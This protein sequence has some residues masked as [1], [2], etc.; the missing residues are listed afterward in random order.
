[1]LRKLRRNMTIVMFCTND[2]KEKHQFSGR[3]ALLLSNF[4]F[5]LKSS[6]MQIILVAVCRFPSTA[7]VSLMTLEGVYIALNITQYAKN[8]HLKSFFLLLPKIV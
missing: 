1:M 5:L 8:Q 2:V 7:L 6:L 4:S 3:A